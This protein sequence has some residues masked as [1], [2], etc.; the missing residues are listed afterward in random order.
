MST[1]DYEAVKA[2]HPLLSVLARMGVDTSGMEGQSEIKRNCFLPGH[3]AG[4]SPGSMKVHPLTQT[5]CCY[6]ETCV[7]N[8]A[9]RRASDVTQ[10]VIDA[11]GVPKEAAVALLDR[12][13]PLPE[14]AIKPGA[15][16]SPV[17][18]R[19]LAEA[20]S[21][22][23]TTSKTHV[24]LGRTPKDRVREAVEAAW[25]F[26]SSDDYHDL[27]V[28]YLAG[29]GIKV[30]ALEEAIGQR[31]VGHTGDK[32]WTRLVRHLRHEG[33]THDELVDSGLG[34]YSDKGTLLDFYVARAILPVRDTEN[35]VIALIGRYVKSDGAGPKYRNPPNTRL[36]QK[37]NHLYR[38]H[39]IPLADD[40]QVVVV[41]GTLDA[42]HIAV[43]AEAAGRLAEFAPITSSG[44]T[45]SEKQ[46]EA[47]ISLSPKAV[48]LALDGDVYGRRHNDELAAEFAQM[49]RQSAIVD[50][51]VDRS[52]PPTKDGPAGYDPDTWLTEHGPAG[53]TALVRSGGEAAPADEVR[54]RPSHA[55]AV[56]YLAKEAPAKQVL[57]TVLAPVAKFETCTAK[58]RYLAAA[59]PVVVSAA[60]AGERAA[61]PGRLAA[62]AEF[63]PSEQRPVWRHELS[64]ALKSLDHPDIARQLQTLM[65]DN[66]PPTLPPPTPGRAPDWE[67]PPPPTPG[68]DG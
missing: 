67:Y 28:K 25:A 27:G 49:G 56:A 45:L 43:A 3:A 57:S 34:T 47:V 54:P 18:E 55:R 10:L 29:R 32:N 65:P 68:L 31:V 14:L 16:A 41:E 58:Q 64:R 53:L 62:T 63:V 59:A 24:D 21:V 19:P 4:L 66:P 20:N 17:D 12:P 42:L 39:Q 30:T 36:Y 60:L 51:P 48:V 13:G 26:Y 15:A 23:G 35:R 52:A 22:K 37:S 8:H 5:W 33:F 50:W 61:A 38:P 6:E 7:G 11:Y 1:I 9:P 2:R 46:R 44:L 40:G